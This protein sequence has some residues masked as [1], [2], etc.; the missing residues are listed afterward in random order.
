MSGRDQPELAPAGPLLA[1]VDRVFADLDWTIPAG[2]LAPGIP[3]RPVRPAALRRWLL[4][5]TTSYHERDAAWAGVVTT[6]RQPGP[7]GQAYRLLALGLALVGLQGFRRRIR[8]WDAQDVPDLT[9]D[10]IAGFYTRL[11]IIDTSAPNIAGRLIDS[12]IGYAARRYRH[13]QSRPRPTPAVTSPDT[14]PLPA[15]S[16][17]G[18]GAGCGREAGMDGALRAAAARLA[19]CGQELHP[20]DLELIAATRIDRRTLRDVA[21]DL[22]LGVDAAY[23]RRQ[24]AEHRLATVLHPPAR[25]PGRPGA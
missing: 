5:T 22:A 13:H 15:I 11:A 10:L 23:K 3:P 20:L 8:I 17:P 7:D 6:T 19:A 24:R 9:A 14:G 4:A 12:A 25:M 2:R 18:W 16:A 1:G 21:A